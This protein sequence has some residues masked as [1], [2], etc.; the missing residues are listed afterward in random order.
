MI[1]IEEKKSGG[2]RFV[3]KNAKGSP[4][5]ESKPFP[6]EEAAQESLLELSSKQRAYAQFE[7]RTDHS[8]NFLFQLKSIRG[9]RL[10]KSTTFSSEAGMENGIKHFRRYLAHWQ[11][12]R[13]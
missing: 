7:R 12:D 1:R 13:S 3:L 11:Q 10:G 9:K 5:F 4:L 8:G 2:F 6:S